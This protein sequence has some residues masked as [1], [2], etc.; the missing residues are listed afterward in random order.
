MHAAESHGAAGTQHRARAEAEEDIEQAEM[1]YLQ[2]DPDAEDGHRQHGASQPSIGRSDAHPADADMAPE[3]GEVLS[4]EA[5]DVGSAHGIA[6]VHDA[7]NVTTG[8]HLGEQQAQ[9]QAPSDDHCTN[10][11]CLNCR[12]ALLSLRASSDL[13]SRVWVGE[14]AETRARLVRSAGGYFV[15]SPD[16]GA[17]H[18]CLRHLEHDAVCF[19]NTVR[20]WW[21][22]KVRNC[23]GWEPPDQDYWSCR[24]AQVANRVWCLAREWAA[25]AAPQLD[26]ERGELECPWGPRLLQALADAGEPSCPG[27]AWPAQ[28]RLAEPPKE[29]ERRRAEA[30]L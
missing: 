1:D 7:Q 21:K 15:V 20:Q 3:E 4:A 28:E 27:L 10:F 24:R 8:G 12:A 26:I 14:F 29:G 18:A 11:A 13:S 23:H 9:A 19:R 5:M 22:V 17:V 16:S 2:G 25:P 30:A 6:A